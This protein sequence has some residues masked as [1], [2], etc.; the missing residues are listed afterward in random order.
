MKIRDSD[1]TILD[2]T[3][4]VVAENGG[5]SVVYESSGG[6]A[7]G[8]N[9]RNLQYR[10]GLTVLLRRLQTMNAVIDEIRVETQKTRR[11]AAEDQALR[12][13]GRQFPILLSAVEDVDTLRRQISR[14]GRKVGQSAERSI[15][16]GGSSRRLRIFVSQ[17]PTDVPALEERLAG[18][19]GEAR[20]S[21]SEV[22]SLA[23]AMEANSSGRGQGY[24]VSQAV[25]KAVEIHAVNRATQYYVAQGWTVEDAGTIESYDLNCTRPSE[26]LHVEVKG[27]STTG[28]SVILTPN[29]VTHA[30]ELYPAVELFIVSNIM[31]DDRNPD[32]PVASGGS[33]RVLR[34]WQ[35][36][37]EHLTAIGYSYSVPSTANPVPTVPQRHEPSA[38]S[39]QPG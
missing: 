35:I 9:P 27:T 19:P 36:R 7:G 18:R 28:E 21:A 8:P 32:H 38:A 33:A 2:A 14:Y 11:L 5:I 25:R 34:N 4:Y 31:V 1:G 13:E 15:Q 37:E 23:E 17:V 16:P 20:A 22:E 39:T 26:E 24:L 10:Q 12:I 29:E 6:R 3:F 30:R